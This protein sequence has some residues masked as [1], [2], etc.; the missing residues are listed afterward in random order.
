MLHFL[1]IF[2]TFDAG[3][4]EV[5]AIQLMQ[6]FGAA[7]RHTVLSLDGK[8]GA[9]AKIHPDVRLD[10]LPGPR[11][12]GTLKTAL[13]TAEQI[14][15]AQPDLVLTYNWGAIEGVVGAKLSGFPRVIHHEDGFGPEESQAPLKRR[16]Y[17]RRAILPSVRAIVV[18]S[19]QLERLAVALWHQPE[20]RVRYL[21][22]GVD[23]SRFRPRSERRAPGP[24]VIGHVGRFRPEKNQLRL[25]RAFAE[26][27]LKNRAELCFVGDGPLLGRARALAA[28]YGVTEEVRFL[29]AVSDPARLYQKFDLVAL[30]SSTEQMPLSIL[31]AMATGLPVV[32]TQVGDVREMIPPTN[33]PFIVPLEEGPALGEALVRLVDDPGLRERLGQQNRAHVEATYALEAC[34]SRH[35]ELYLEIAGT[36]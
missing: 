11:A 19:R 15:R 4:L 33:H 22:N 9:I 8:I 6:L 18:P 12:K 29:G 20:P 27:G 13:H 1:H 16:V 2:A 23:L 17:F 7:A 14:Q 5:R 36:A 10:L 25:I 32:S 21:P 26:S 34:L 31:E 30:S 24:V 28:E 35:K 3:G